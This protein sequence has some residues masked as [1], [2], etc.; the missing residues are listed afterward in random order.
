LT[1]LLIRVIIENMIKSE[2]TKQKIRQ[3]RQQTREK[4]K[5]QVVKVY[6]LKVDESHLN[7]IQKEWL[8]K[9]FIEA[10]WFYNYVLQQEDI[11]NPK[12]RN[13]RKV[14]V[15]MLDHFEER[16]LQYL[17]SHMKR[18]IH[19]HICDSIKSLSTLKKRSH[20]I[21]KLKYKSEINSIPLPT[22]GHTWDIQNG[23]IRVQLL[24]KTLPVMGLEQIPSGCEFAN[25]NFIRKPSG[26]YVQVT[27]FQPK[28]SRIKTGRE[29]GLDFGIKDNIVT[30]DGK[31]FNIKVPETQRLKKLQKRFNKKKKGSK[32]RYKVQHQIKKEYEKI[33][34]QKQD[35]INKIVFYLNKTYDHIFIQDE[36]IKQWQS[37][38]FGK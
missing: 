1:K 25:A 10:K 3:S 19:E 34:N 17:G 15:K 9:I 6:S 21:G 8:N 20:K 16:E 35:Q 24:K 4:R 31:R 36:M 12:I 2:E 27:T 28:V 38:W 32:Q 22:F 30:S 29:V 26:Y 14:Q 18:G 7:R 37:G 11:F 33:G 13:V 5:S 23:R